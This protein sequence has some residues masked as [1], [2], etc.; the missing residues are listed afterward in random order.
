MNSNK[1]C[2]VSAWKRDSE[3][4]AELFMLIPPLC[5]YSDGIAKVHKHASIVT[6]A[7]RVEG[8]HQKESPCLSR[9]H[10]TKGMEVTL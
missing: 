2:H 4:D 6:A 7:S 3:I 8:K 5:T 1:S 9:H 10:V